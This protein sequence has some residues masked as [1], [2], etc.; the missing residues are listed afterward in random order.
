[1]H[2]VHGAEGDKLIEDDPKKGMKIENVHPG[3]AHA[4]LEQIRAE[5]LDLLRVSECF[6]LMALN[7][8]RDECQ[9]HSCV[10]HSNEIVPFSSSNAIRAIEALS[11]ILETDNET[12]L[13]YVKNLM[14][15]GWGGPADGIPPL[16]EED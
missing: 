3:V 6:T 7:K 16:P 5:A 8:E 4:D 13:R 11:V 10:I 15:H 1:M 2:I 9:I 12:A 14:D